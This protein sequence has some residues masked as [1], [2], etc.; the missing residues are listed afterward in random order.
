MKKIL[1]IFAS[2]SL[3]TTGASSAVACG[4][5]SNFDP[6]NLS[7]WDADQKKAIEHDYLKD[8]KQWY[9]PNP[10]LFPL[11]KYWDTW[12]HEN[13]IQNVLKV[14]NKKINIFDNYGKVPNTTITYNPQ[15]VDTMDT[16][17]IFTKGL[18]VDIKGDNKTIKG[19]L[20]IELKL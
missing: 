5:K 4:S 15:P 18:N 12:K 17:V 14:I 19:E 7:T 13:E 8:W 3:I 9:Q 11:Q 1:N 20:D 6:S 16:K 10:K 2:L